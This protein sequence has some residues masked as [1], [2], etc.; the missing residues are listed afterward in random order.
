MKCLED[1][2]IVHLGSYVCFNH[3]VQ[4]VNH[5]SIKVH[6]EW[7]LTLWVLKDTIVTSILL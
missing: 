4:P 5:Y 7:L 3:H 1:G 2:V 6:T